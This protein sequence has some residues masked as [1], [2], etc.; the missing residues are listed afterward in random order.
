MLGNIV[1]PV[2][3]EAAQVVSGNTNIHVDSIEANPYQP[4]TK[5]DE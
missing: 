2:H 4:R 5:F 1:I 3:K